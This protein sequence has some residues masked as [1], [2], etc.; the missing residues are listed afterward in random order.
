MSAEGIFLGSSLQ[1]SDLRKENNGTL[2]CQ[3]TM[4]E[5]IMNIQNGMP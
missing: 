5:T 3:V 4:L 1:P 2:R